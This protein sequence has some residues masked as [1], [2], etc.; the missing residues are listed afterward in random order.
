[1]PRRTQY[2]ERTDGTGRHGAGSSWPTGGTDEIDYPDDPDARPVEME[3]RGQRFSDQ[4]RTDRPTQ[5]Y[6]DGRYRDRADRHQSRYNSN[7][8]GR[9][10]EGRFSGVGPKN[11]RRPDERIRD[12]VCD[13]LTD[14]AELNASDMTIGVNEGEVTLDGT[15]D[16]RR[17]KRLAEDCA[18]SVSGVAH[19]QNNLRISKNQTS[20]ER[21]DI[22]GNQP[23]PTG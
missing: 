1:M 8:R 17:A 18:E 13:R 12:D 20:S 5:Y 2:D 15:V 4:A 11:Y 6:D 3:D 19:C 23:Q 22:T 16:S 10:P 9:A 7:Y 14:E 21:V